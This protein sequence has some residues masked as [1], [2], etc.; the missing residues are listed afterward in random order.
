V[1]YNPED[2]SRVAV[3]ETAV[4]LGDGYARE[5]R[6]ADG[7]HESVSLWELELAK[8]LIRQKDQQHRLRPHSWL[9]HL[10]EARELIE[11]RQAEQRL[12]RRKL[13]QLR[14]RHPG[15]PGNGSVV[16][17]S[18]KEQITQA[19]KLIEEMKIRDVDPRACLLDNLE[20]VL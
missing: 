10:F 2:V 19:E 5:L 11:Q 7:S 1:R 17:A 16:L 18:E 8:D 9:V 14:E 3:F 15:R 20:E 4:W 13:Q 12:I 6:L